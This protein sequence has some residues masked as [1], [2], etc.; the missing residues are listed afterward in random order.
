MKKEPEPPSSSQEPFV[1]PPDKYR[2]EK[3]EEKIKEE[4]EE[5]E[6]KM[7]K[8]VEAAN[9]ATVD[10]DMDT[11]QDDSAQAGTKEKDK[12]A[13][14]SEKEVAN[15]VIYDGVDVTECEHTSVL[16][17]LKECFP[18][19]ITMMIGQASTTRA[20]HIQL[21]IFTCSGTRSTVSQQNPEM[22]TGM[23]LMRMR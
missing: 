11:T 8:A 10:D 1:P 21:N 22:N 20:I 23:R 2:K 3:S 16:R 9:K 15:K 5:E 17:R 6:K 12:P 19:F 18:G 7:K 14:S 13:S 4:K